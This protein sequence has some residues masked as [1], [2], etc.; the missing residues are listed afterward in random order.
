LE[1]FEN[2]NLI[3]QMIFTSKL[4]ILNLT[5]ARLSGLSVFLDC[6]IA[7]FSHLSILN[8]PNV[9]MMDH[10]LKV[11]GVC[12]TNLVQQILQGKKLELYNV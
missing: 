4:F 12:S 5:L 6:I 7:Q 10:A 11:F 8:I 9:I 2:S 3:D 1:T